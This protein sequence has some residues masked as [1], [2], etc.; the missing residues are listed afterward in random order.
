MHFSV[1]KEVDW[2]ADDEAEDPKSRLWLKKRYRLTLNVSLG[3]SKGKAKA[4]RNRSGCKCEPKKKKAHHP[5][6]NEARDSTMPDNYVCYGCGKV[7]SAEHHEQYPLKGGKEPI[8]SLCTGCRHD[9]KARI[10][11]GT[12]HSISPLQT[13]IDEWQWCANCGNLRS[14]EYH[15]RYLSGDPLP[16]W[17]EVCGKCMIIEQGKKKT[18]QLRSYFKGQDMKEQSNS[19]GDNDGPSRRRS[20]RYALKPDSSRVKGNFTSLRPSTHFPTRADQPGDSD[21][22]KQRPVM[23]GTSAAHI[24]PSS[25]HKDASKRPHV[26]TSFRRA[27]CE[28]DESDEDHRS[29]MKRE[30]QEIG[31]QPKKGRQPRQAAASHN[32]DSQVEQVLRRLGELR[33]HLQPGKENSTPSSTITTA[34]QPE[35]ETPQGQS[36]PSPLP[37]K[38]TVAK[39]TITISGTYRAPAFEQGHHAADDAEADAELCYSAH[40]SDSDVIDPLRDNPCV[41]GTVTWAPPAPSSTAA[42][43]RRSAGDS[44]D[45]DDDDVPRYSGWSP[46]LGKKVWEVDSDEEREIE[47]KRAELD[48]ERAK[49]SPSKGV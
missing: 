39:P 14:D 34:H 35:S 20:R 22:G 3:A 29:H 1:T 15:E 28:T 27:T 42:R 13:Q 19:K 43:R 2:E 31:H 24:V 26:Q 41:S 30:H 18:A 36:E 16:P 37:P 12:A 6:S 11:D 17:A 47:K 9:R 38:P 46:I 5:E 48:W 4:W 33:D 49:P 44:D 25:V 7:R 8:P 45:R 32:P 23:S 10:A 21:H 40:A